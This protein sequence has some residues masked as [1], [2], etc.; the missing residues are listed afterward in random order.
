M[1]EI[2]LWFVN[3]VVFCLGVFFVVCLLALIPKRKNEFNNKLIEY[4]ECSREQQERQ[5]ILLQR[6]AE[7]QERKA[8]L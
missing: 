1:N 8:K 4:W 6:I 3:G 5:L 2:L 7:S